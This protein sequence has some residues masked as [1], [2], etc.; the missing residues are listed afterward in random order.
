MTAA[1]R[2]CDAVILIGFGGPTSAGEVRPFLDRILAGRL[3][4]RE[5]YEEVV[6]HY[7]SLGGRSPYNDLTMRQAVALENRLHQTGISSPV[8]AGF[9]YAP[10][11]L[12]DALQQLHKRGVRRALAFV[13][14][15]HRSEASWDRYVNEITAARERLSGDAPEVEFPPLW[16]DHPGFIDAVSDRA[17][18]AL[19]RLAA[20]AREH[21]ELIFTTHSIPLSMAGRPSYVDQLNE[22]ARAVA[23]NLGRTNWTIAFQSRS[24]NPR[25]PWL[26][27]DVKDVLRG[28]KARSALVIP[29][30]FLCDHIEVLYDLDVEAAEVAR[31]AGIQMERAGTVSDHPSFIQMMVDIAKAYLSSASDRSR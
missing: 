6:H 19:D 30:G 2:L 31:R 13:L 22:S 15:P 4:P 18:A 7:E 25:E 16:H 28:L 29:V 23:D 9:R 24:G 14:A 8:V 21:A 11:F 3:V 17:R 1:K 27:P 10:P 5:R 20:D 12:D 26:E